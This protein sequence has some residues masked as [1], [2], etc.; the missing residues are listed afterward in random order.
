MN[1]G[2]AGAGVGGSGRGVQPV[3]GYFI[4]LRVSS[5]WSSMKVLIF[6]LSAMRDYYHDNQSLKILPIT[7]SSPGKCSV[8]VSPI[9][10]A[11]FHPE[12]NTPL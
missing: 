8:A 5:N 4:S 1:L 12:L 7:S 3:R 2:G 9:K 6:S 11:T 10:N